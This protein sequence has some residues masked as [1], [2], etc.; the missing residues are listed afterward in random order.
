MSTST[1]TL[2]DGTALARRTVEETA[3]RA[4]EITRR[5]GVTPVSRPSSSARTR[6]P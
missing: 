6:P 2:M 1:A 3:A 5:T 4:A